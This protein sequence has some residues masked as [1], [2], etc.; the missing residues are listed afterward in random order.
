VSFASSGF[1]LNPSSSRFAFVQY[2]RMSFNNCDGCVTVA[3]L[4][5]ML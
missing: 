2:Q 5:F 1:Q 3:I 4:S